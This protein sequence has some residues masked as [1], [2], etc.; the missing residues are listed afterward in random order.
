VAETVASVTGA[1]VSQNDSAAK[2]A[3]LLADHHKHMLL[4]ACLSVICATAFPVY[5]S[6][7]HRLLRDPADPARG[8]NLRPQGAI[9]PVRTGGEA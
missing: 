4:A 6:K 7:L 1:N 2:I 8:P 3:N 5:L 9:N